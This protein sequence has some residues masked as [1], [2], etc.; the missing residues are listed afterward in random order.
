MRWFESVIAWLFPALLVKGTPWAAEWER[1]E[2]AAFIFG[3]R[4]MLPIIALAYVLHYFFYDM[5]MGLEPLQ[6]WFWFRFSIAFASLAGLAFYL[7]PLA[8]QLH[9]YRLPAIGICA[10]FCIGQAYVALW[11]DPSAW[12]W[13]F[14]LVI[15]ATMIL[16][17][18]AL[19]SFVFAAL[20][21][22]AQSL[23]LAQAGVPVTYIVSGTLVTFSMVALIR[24]SYLSDV[25]NFLLNQENMLVQQK[26]SDLNSDFAGR[27]RAFIP[28]VIAQRLQQQVDDEGRTVLEASLDVLAAKQLDIAC[29]FSDIRGFT[30][31]SRDLDKFIRHSVIPEMK[32]CSDAVE[33]HMGI[34]RKVGDLVFA[35]FDSEY[36]KLN[37]LRAV[38]AGLEIARLNADM[39]ATATMVNIR[40]YILISSGEAVVGNIGGLDSSVEITALGP[41]VNFLSRVDE[42][43]KEPAL[44]RLLRP[45]D[46]LLCERSHRLLSEL[47]LDVR[48]QR[49]DLP[50]L[51]LVI[52]D[53]PG[54]QALYILRPDD[55]NYQGVMEPYNYIRS[56]ENGRAE[57]LR[58]QLDYVAS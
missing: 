40:R 15:G 10:G 16:R 56:Q 14:L 18:T 55:K 29:L 36:V 30:Q 23:I 54:T 51:G 38:A 27:I 6:R 1:K 47:G 19:N 25:R 48:Y 34:P 44:A 46:I 3:V 49:V 22:L 12:V 58:R 43:T 33:R 35:Y 31:D 45:G 11:H 53:F 41:P 9:W 39:N 8:W 4:F 21:I 37:L 2:R 24:S 28:K 26:I 7:T 17:M 20:V 57:S 32:V 13:C 50:E 42:L 52:R 5:A